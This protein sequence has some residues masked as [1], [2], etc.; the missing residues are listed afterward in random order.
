MTICIRRRLFGIACFIFLTAIAAAAQ[1]QHAVPYPRID[2][3]IGYKVDA[4]WPLEKAPGGDWAAMSSVAVAPDGNVW[5]FN[6]GKIPIQVYSPQGKLLKAWGEGMFT[7]A[8]TIRFDNTGNLWI[9]DT[10]SQTVRKFSEDGKVLMTLGTLNQAGEDQTHM[11]QP[12]D[13]AFAPNGD[14][15]VSDGYGNDRVVI[16]DK[17]GKFVRAW[18]KLGARPGEFSQPHSVALDSKGRVYVADR[19]NAR[20]QIFDSTGKFLTEWKNIITPWYIVITKNDEIYVCGSSP[21]RWSDVPATQVMLATPPKDQIL[22]KLDTEGHIKLLTVFPKGE[23][24]KEKP[25]DLNWV[26]SMAV[27]ADGTIYFGDVQGKRAQKF[28]PVGIQ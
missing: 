12:N 19:N 22:L 7:N 20:I 21:T 25:G 23:N 28:V 18:G 1:P 16:F 24:G 9:I 17:N 4:N 5:T 8:H 13:V 6:R 26:H 15:Y 3:A 14:I 10:N 11:N 27:A 2:N